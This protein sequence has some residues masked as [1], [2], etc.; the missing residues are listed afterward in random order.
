MFNITRKEIEWAGRTLTLETG[1]IARQADGAVFVTYGETSVLC[2]VVAQKTP[3]VDID[4][5]PL[6]VHYKEMA[7]AA[8]KI[9]G[10]FFK[11]EGRPSEREIL[12]SRL[13]DRPI[14]PLFPENFFNEVQI[15]CTVM[16]YDGVNDSDIAALVGA[17]AAL[18]ISGIPFEGPIAAS[19]VGIFDGELV[20][21]PPMK[22]YT[23]SALDL[24]VSG[25]GSAVLMVE[26]EAREL[27]EERMLEAVT[28][29]HA[30]MQ[31]VIKM[32]A[33]FAKEAA[34]PMMQVACGNDNSKLYKLV[35]GAIENELREAL[36]E[37]VKHLR[38]EKKQAIKANLIADLS[39]KINDLAEEEGDSYTKAELVGA[40]NK[41]EERIVRGNIIEK[42]LR[43]D[44][45]DPKTIRP[46]VTEVG[47][48]AK[49]HGSSLFTR[50]ETQSIVVATLGSAQDE[51]MI[52]SLDGDSKLAFM[53]HYNFPPYSVG[54]HTPVRAPGRREIGHGKLAWRAMNPVMPSKE[55]FPYTIRCVSE[56][57]ESNGSSS[58]ATVCGTSLALMDAGVPI[59]N[60]VAGIAMGLV[61]DGDKFVVLSDIMGDEDHLG[62]MDF[63]VA[64]TSSGVTA[65]QMDI[66]I[67]GIT[68]E[69]MKVALAQAKEGRLHILSK[70]SES[71]T[72]ARGSVSKNAP[73]IVS[74]NIPKDKIREVIGSGGKVIRE[75]CEVSGAKV[76]IEDSG[77]ISVSAV[78]SE[79]LDKAIKMINDIVAEAEV[80]KIYEGK[81][82]K[83]LEFGAFVNFLGAKDGLLHIS[84]I[85]S[86]RVANVS[87]VLKEGDMVKV[88]VIGLDKGKVRL[89]AKVV[90]QETGEDLDPNFTPSDTPPPSRSSS[91][92]RSGDR[93]RN[94]RG[95]DRGERGAPPSKKK[96]F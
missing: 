92:P 46:I 86:E 73:T 30:G 60:A 64:G 42:Q 17:S 62:D 5:F 21:N 8:G 40:F 29:G 33:E 61:K 54:E 59:K 10:G 77:I 24:I 55:Q 15:I 79:S 90:N 68:T 89:S 11:R 43:I 50:G 6:T 14:R 52:D 22:E 57:T 47:L 32:I 12:T 39:E 4:F 37:P 95:G 76:D 63:K 78:N 71:L 16:S 74:F 58:M 36:M 28:F 65:L 69:I 18:A 3:R 85:Q 48:L 83:L 19:R 53:L 25:T 2:T 49:T 67:N 81:V 96:F 88:K 72:E 35:S 38:S 31:P 27:S 94:D 93:D 13:I 9:P 70:M 82:V 87:D 26:S 7:F 56:I 80:G 20:L 91:K 23:N 41:L 1:K 51:Q 75:I 34:K 66:K 45:R 44:G 84:E